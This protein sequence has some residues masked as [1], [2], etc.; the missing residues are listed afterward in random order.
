MYAH[1]HTRMHTSIHVIYIYIHTYI[2]LHTKMSL[3]PP[4]SLNVSRDHKLDATLV[5]PSVVR[6]LDEWEQQLA[7]KETD[8]SLR[9]AEIQGVNEH[10]FMCIYM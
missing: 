5:V 1:A 2:H 10:M 3:S 6:R 4:R 8:I 9:N 7:K